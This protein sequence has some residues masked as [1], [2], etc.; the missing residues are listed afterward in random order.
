MEGQWLT[1][2]KAMVVILVVAAAVFTLAKP[3]CLRFMSQ[4]DFVR[5]RNVWF[6]LTLTAFVAPSFWIYVFVALPVLWVTMRREINPVA[7]YL[8]LMQVIPPLGAHIPVIGINEL[9]RLDS[10]RLLSFGILIPAA[11]RFAS[12]NRQSRNRLSGVDLLLISYAVLHL[13][14]LVPYET[15][16]HT[17]RRGFLFF[18]D[19]W[20]VYFVV[21]R[22]CRKAD[23][24][25]E[26]MACFVLPSLVFAPLALFEAARGWLLYDGLGQEWGSA[27]PFSYL[28]RSDVLRAQVSAGHSIALGFIM[29]I[30]FGF[31][32]CLQAR[33]KS[34][35]LIMTVAIWL[36]A[37]L[38]AAYSRAPWLVAV[39]IF[40]V[41][42][43]RDRK[44]PRRLFTAL[45]VSVAMGIAIV[46]S[47]IGGR[48]IDNLPFVGT[49]DAGNITYR[50]QLAERSWEL[51]KQNPLFGSPFVLLYLEDL[52]QGQGIIDLMNT[53]AMIAM[54]YGLVGLTLFLGAFLL[55]M[56][57]VR[58]VP[59]STESQIGNTLIACMM[60]ILLMMATG[61]FG[62]SLAQMFYVFMGLA[63]GYSR[64][65][66]Y[67]MAR[68]TLSDASRYAA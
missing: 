67:R 12:A 50:Q 48:V 44:G 28:L 63:D 62:T 57:R 47:P 27:I 65:Q 39:A 5:R 18:I 60:G 2:L 14:L 4:D 8:L 56:W 15:F 30:G 1:N 61:S 11:W 31:W 52:R 40:F 17:M 68:A 37:G 20:L 66:Q 38:I 19:A 45:L 22:T 10:Y 9:F 32:I 64:S 13:L 41:Y 16:T 51:V 43:A 29:A 34:F 58:K 21:S 26:A 3:V 25:L 35:A 54:Y 23:Q 7:L 6:V 24:I 33:V 49:V 42:L 46:A 55:A 59:D 53:Y 36:A